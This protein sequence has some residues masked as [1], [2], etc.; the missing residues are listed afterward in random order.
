M[1]KIMNIFN[2]KY[3]V[4][5]HTDA[6]IKQIGRLIIVWNVVFVIFSSF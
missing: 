2:K 5:R 3:F 1:A 4:G 6:R